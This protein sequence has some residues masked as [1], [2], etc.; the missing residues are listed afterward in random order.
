MPNGAAETMVTRSP[1]GTETGAWASGGAAPRDQ[2]RAATPAGRLAPKVVIASNYGVDGALY[3]GLCWEAVQVLAEI[4][5]GEIVAPGRAAQTPRRRLAAG[6]R[7]ALN[8][9][10]QPPVVPTTLGAPCDLFFY[11]CMRPDNLAPLLSLNGWRERSGLKAAFLFETWIH[12]APDYRAYL[13]LLDDFDHVFLFNAASVPAVQA[14][15]KTPVSALPAAI[16]VLKATPFPKNADRA[17]DVYGMGRMN[18]DVHDQLLD[19][20]A[21]HELLYVWDRGPSQAIHG[22]ERARFRTYHLIRSA[23][24]FL[25]FGFTSVPK[26]TGELGREDAIPARIFEG[27]AAG[28]AMIGTTPDVPEF[29][30]LFDWEDPLFDIPDDPVDM[31]AFLAG[32]DPERLRRAGVRNALRSL[33]RHDWAYRWTEVLSRL[34]LSAHAALEERT[35]RL[36]RLANDG[37]RDAPL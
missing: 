5:G 3:N 8:G 2:T 15:T 37:Q 33:E 12:K 32:I 10:K 11:V 19:M 23:R 25:S 30:T 4:T 17:I 34:G 29:E 36:Q 26:K 13:R 6:L 18:E 9:I 7:H 21:A 28:A 14:L 31:R 20:T 35:A 1:A 16:D 27:A 22:F 24:M